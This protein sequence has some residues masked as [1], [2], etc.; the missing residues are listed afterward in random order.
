M[1]IRLFEPGDEQGI[2]DVFCMQ[3]EDAANPV[4]RARTRQR[5]E[6][7]LRLFPVEPGPIMVVAEEAGRIVGFEQLLPHR[8]V[9]AGETC[10]GGLSCWTVVDP[11]CRGRGL[12]VSMVQHAEAKA[13]ELGV[14]FVYGWPNQNSRH[15]FVKHLHW[16]ELGHTLR[17]SG[18]VGLAASAAD[19]AA[20]RGM[21]L[22]AQLLAKLAA[23]QAAAATR[24]DLVLAPDLPWWYADLWQQVR[25]SSGFT[26][27]RDERFLR[28]KGF[29]QG[30]LFAWRPEPQPGERAL[31]ALLPGEAG[32]W[33][34]SDAVFDAGAEAAVAALLREAAAAL[35]PWGLAH[36]VTWQSADARWRAVLDRC[37]FARDVAPELAAYG[38]PLDPD[39]ELP[40]LEQWDVM[41]SA[42]DLW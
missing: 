34:V 22:P 5:L 33:T 31:L 35:V 25:A 11:S 20:R 27:D 28:Y 16:R 26:V 40:P 32:V 24:R 18:K 8:F 19:A 21:G 4:V 17:R 1:E 15:G 39:M 23:L 14:R 30:Y 9:R 12:F 10:Y 41:P 36:L 7:N 42:T 38:K 29:G 13:G 6:A 37:P 3:F 2:V